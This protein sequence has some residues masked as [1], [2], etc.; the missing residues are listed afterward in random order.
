MLVVQQHAHRWS[1][2]YESSGR[3]LR[4]SCCS[5]HSLFVSTEIGIGLFS[6]C[7]FLLIDR[8]LNF[9]DGR[10]PRAVGQ[11]NGRRL[12]DFFHFVQKCKMRCCCRRGRDAMRCYESGKCYVTRT[13]RKNEEA[14]QVRRQDREMICKLADC[15]AYHTL[16]SRI[17]HVASRSAVWKPK[18]PPPTY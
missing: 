16:R 12:L 15:R 6:G 1:K 5:S 10:L 13:R 18:A 3:Q 4:E 9:E 11:S 17:L 2:G 8:E 14:D 7:V